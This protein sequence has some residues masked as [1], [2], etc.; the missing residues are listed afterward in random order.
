MKLSTRSRYGSRAMLDLALHFGEEPIALKDVARRQGVSERYLENIMTVLVAS[1]L[2]MSVRGKQGGFR[3][4]K[5]PQEM[6]LGDIVQAVEGSLAPAPCVDDSVACNR[7]PECVTHDIWSKLR[8]SVVSALN[9]I[10]LRDM[11]DMQ[12]HKQGGAGSQMYFI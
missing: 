12:V 10:T 3:L 4:A 2:A 6:R 8:E 1:G 5:P 11:M 9:S 7:T